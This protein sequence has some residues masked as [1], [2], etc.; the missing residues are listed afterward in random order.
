MAG[1][2]ERHLEARRQP[3]GIEPTRIDR[4]ERQLGA[5]KG[6]Q[7]AQAR[8]PRIFHCYPRAL[9]DEQA[10][11]QKER[12]LGAHGDQDL[13]FRRRF[14]A[15]ANPL[16][17][18]L[19]EQRIIGGRARTRVRRKPALAE[20]LFRALAPFGERKELV[21][22]LPADEWVAVRPLGRLRSRYQLG[23]AGRSRPLHN[24][25]WSLARFAGASFGCGSGSL[26]CGEAA[27][28]LL[29]T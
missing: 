2:R 17:Q 25:E 19:D 12:V 18:L 6:E 13:L 28:V 29:L 1:G 24:V 16:L 23:K 9:P 14:R 4:D 22:C 26:Y 7:A 15:A 20:R 21:V 10:A 3:L 11:Q 27:S 5:R 8:V